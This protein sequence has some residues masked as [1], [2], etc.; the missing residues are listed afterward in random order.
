M[1]FHSFRIGPIRGIQLADLSAVPAVLVITGPNG[2]GKS[3]LLYELWHQRGVCA[4]PDTK[5]IY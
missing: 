5:C 3:T 4:E 1:A 2:A